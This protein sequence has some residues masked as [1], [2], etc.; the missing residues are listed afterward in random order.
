ML[1]VP[2]SI[3]LVTAPVAPLAELAGTLRLAAAAPSLAPVKGGY[4]I[5]FS[6]G[7]E[8]AGRPVTLS[9]ATLMLRLNKKD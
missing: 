7:T 5:T 1:L 9:K 2:R 4:A 3:T 8:A 6:L